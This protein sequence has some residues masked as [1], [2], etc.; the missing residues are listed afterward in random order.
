MPDDMTEEQ[1]EKFVEMALHELVNAKVRVLARVVAEFGAGHGLFDVISVWHHAL[2]ACLQLEGQEF[3][4]LL[5]H[6]GD[7]VAMLRTDGITEEQLEKARHNVLELA[8]LYQLGE[9]DSP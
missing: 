3:L 6:N 8:R 9:M 5:Q 4:K 7:L 2:L 1:Y